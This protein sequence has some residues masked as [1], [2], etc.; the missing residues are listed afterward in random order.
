MIWKYLKSTPDIWEENA[1][2]NKGA[3][4]PPRVLYRKFAHTIFYLFN[5]FSVDISH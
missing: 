4:S 2:H 1:K 5:G 3:E